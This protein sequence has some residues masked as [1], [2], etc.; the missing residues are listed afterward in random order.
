MCSVPSTS[1]AQ[2]QTECPW[3]TSPCTLLRPALPPSLLPWWTPVSALAYHSE[4]FHRKPLTCY[5]IS[6]SAVSRRSFR[7]LSRRHDVFIGLA[8]SCSRLPAV[9]VTCDAK[10]GWPR[11]ES[12]NYLGHE[13]VCDM[14][15]LLVLLHEIICALFVNETQDTTNSGVLL[16]IEK[17]I[18]N[19]LVSPAQKLMQYVSRTI[20]TKVRLTVPTHLPIKT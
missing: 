2:Q 14:R 10:W 5:S 1:R 13:Y 17:P 16:A 7:A 9:L 8:H 15:W 6:S 19:L 11:L 12:N 3:V 20:T 4:R 18:L